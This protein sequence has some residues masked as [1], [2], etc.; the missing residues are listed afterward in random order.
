MSYTQVQSSE[1]LVTQSWGDPSVNLG[2]KLFKNSFVSEATE[3][4]FQSLGLPIEPLKSMRTNVTLLA[5][6]QG[7]LKRMQ[8]DSISEKVMKGFFVLGL[9]FIIS[10]VAFEVFSLGFCPL[11]FG[12]LFAFGTY[13]AFT[14]RFSAERSIIEINQEIQKLIPEIK[15]FIKINRDELVNVLDQKISKCNEELD[16]LER[17]D[18]ILLGEREGKI[19][20]YKAECKKAVKELTKTA[21]Y[22]QHLHKQGTENHY[23]YQHQSE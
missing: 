23:Q 6:E 3:H 18:K 7:R 8:E 5:V 4:I 17:E 11:L 22:Y 12:G 20:K 15:T 14:R 10:C 21:N 16:T 2:K 13:H 1:G 19:R 9:V